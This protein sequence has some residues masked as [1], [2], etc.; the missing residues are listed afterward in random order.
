MF[1]TPE[2]KSHIEEQTRDQADCEAWYRHRKPRITASNCKRAFI[3]PTTS[4]TKVMQE[5]MCM[6]STI[7]TSFMK[8]GQLSDCGIVDFK[9]SKCG[10][11]ISEKYPFLGASPDSL[12]GADGLVEA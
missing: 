11:F 9:V 3:K 10:L 7:S 6:N 4:P 12:V 8:D 1:V 5:I 2:Q